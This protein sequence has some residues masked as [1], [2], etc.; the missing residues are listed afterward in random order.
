M[1]IAMPDSR[2][3]ICGRTSTAVKRP[4]RSNDL[5]GLDLKQ[6]QTTHTP[7]PSLTDRPMHRTADH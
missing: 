6:A 2:K 1:T 3:Q 7:S 5:Q 4:A